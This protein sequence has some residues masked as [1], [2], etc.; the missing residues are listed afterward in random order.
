MI[1]VNAAIASATLQGNA[2]PNK[3]TILSSSLSNGLATFSW[4]LKR[5]R[6][7]K[8]AWTNADKNTTTPAPILVASGTTTA[9][10][11]GF[12]VA[13][14]TLSFE[15]TLTILDETGTIE[16]PL[17]RKT[18]LTATGIPT[19]VTTAETS[20]LAFAISR[21]G[22]WIVFGN[23]NGT[24]VSSDSGATFTRKTILLHF[25]TA[26]TLLISDDGQTILS[27]Q[28]GN[29]TGNYYVSVDGGTTFSSKQVVSTLFTL[30]SMCMIGG[31]SANVLYAS[32]SSSNGGIYQSTDFGATFTRK[33]LS[34]SVAQEKCRGVACSSSGRIV[35]VATETSKQYLSH[36]YGSSFYEVSTYSTITSQTLTVGYRVLVHPLEY[37]VAYLGFTNSTPAVMYTNIA[38]LPTNLAVMNLRDSS[39]M[40][41]L[42]TLGYAMD[43]LWS[44]DRNDRIYYVGSS[45]QK[46]YF[47]NPI[48]TSS[49]NGLPSSLQSTTTFT[50]SRIQVSEDGRYLV[51]IS[52]TSLT[53]IRLYSETN[54]ATF[55][56]VPALSPSLTDAG[57]AT[58]N[59]S[60]S[61]PAPTLLTWFPP[62]L[63][64]PPSTP[65]SS[66][67]TTATISGF[68]PNVLYTFRL[69]VLSTTESTTVVTAVATTSE[70]RR[71]TL[72]TFASGFPKARY[73]HW[74][75]LDPNSLLDTNLNVTATAT[76]VK[77]IKDK[78]GGTKTLR[79]N[80]DSTT[81]DTTIYK[82]TGGMGQSF[83]YVQAG[84]NLSSKQSGLKVNA[85][86]APAL[87]PSTAG[88]TLNLFICMRPKVPGS[89]PEGLVMNRCLTYLPKHFDIKLESTLVGNGTST[90][91]ATGTYSLYGSTAPTYGMLL[92]FKLKCFTT[93]TG[94]S[95]NVWRNG[96][97]LITAT[98]AKVNFQEDLT[99]PISLFGRPDKVQVKMVEF[100]EA[101]VFATE[102]TDSERLMVEAYFANK[103]NFFACKYSSDDFLLNPYFH[104]RYAVASM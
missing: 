86:D 79:F 51:G 90:F 32:G 101:I 88:G 48:F 60:L 99:A 36:D 9:S 68:F 21:N 59:W 103:W 94:F 5:A 78:S 7:V 57:V 72:W 54:L 45:D 31:S 16:S 65:Y 52:G 25:S 96:A 37:Y 100:G 24:F 14:N 97:A 1:T 53:L 34:N 55:S 23:T 91:A 83:A 102:V 27:Y 66:A 13:Y 46:V 93:D 38:S 47:L 43:Q 58:L 84:G 15:F 85:T 61:T 35:A 41:Q 17:N 77:A 80:N 75:V 76:A 56:S 22:Q 74:D 2:V 49:T 50:D 104:A 87:L 64:A 29:T 12:T 89:S 67:T 69:L 10:I 98:L 11:P 8:I 81:T 20:F 82:T 18:V 70:I 71:P 92:N 62:T 44:L 26:Y 28:S 63:T 73:A 42:G 6:P 39:S 95:V 30:H 4:S 40:S 33:T 3:L 19:E